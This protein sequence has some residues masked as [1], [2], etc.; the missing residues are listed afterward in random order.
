MRCRTSSSPQGH[1]HSVHTVGSPSSCVPRS[2]VHPSVADSLGTGT[3]ASASSASPSPP[4]IEKAHGRFA[5]PRAAP[6]SHT[7]VI[8]IISQ[9]LC[10]NL[11]KKVKGFMFFRNS[12]PFCTFLHIAKRGLFPVTNC[13]RN[14]QKQKCFKP[15]NHGLMSYFDSAILNFYYR[16]FLFFPYKSY[17]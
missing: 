8:I 13:V 5:L 6:Y 10:A 2:T 11:C 9:T 14:C 1:G 7:F 12:S 3:G 16:D 4:G 17:I 15:S